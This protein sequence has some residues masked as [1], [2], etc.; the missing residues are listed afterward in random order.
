M[1]RPFPHRVVSEPRWLLPTILF[2]ALAG[3]VLQAQSAANVLH[4]W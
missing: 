3:S 4:A 1:I 2:V